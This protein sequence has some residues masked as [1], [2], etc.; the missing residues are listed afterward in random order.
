MD[1][2]VG[3]LNARAPMVLLNEDDALAL[4]KIEPS[5]RIEFPVRIVPHGLSTSACN[6]CP[7]SRLP[8]KWQ[9]SRNPHKRLAGLMHRKEAAGPAPVLTE[10]EG[11]YT[12]R[13][14]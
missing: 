11:A 6:A 4:V 8:F 3:Q 5:L 2:H 7:K 1:L 12:G 14:G 13:H 9:Q 10:G